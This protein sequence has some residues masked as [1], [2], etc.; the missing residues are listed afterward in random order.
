MRIISHPQG[1][2]RMKVFAFFSRRSASLSFFFEKKNQKT[3]IL[4]LATVQRHNE[5]VPFAISGVR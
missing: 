4:D 1:L 2:N 5:V 3:F